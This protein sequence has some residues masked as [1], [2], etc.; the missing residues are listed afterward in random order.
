MPGLGVR[1]PPRALETLKHG[2]NRTNE[3][4]KSLKHERHGNTENKFFV[5]PGFGKFCVS[6]IKLSGG[7]QKMRFK[8]VPF[9]IIA[10][11]TLLFFYLPLRGDIIHLKGGRKFEGQIV[12]ETENELRLRIQEGIFLT[13]K[14]EHIEKIEKKK[15][16]FEICQEKLIQAKTAKDFEAAL[17]Y[18]RDE[19]LKNEELFSKIKEG[20]IS[21]RKRENPKSFCQ[22]C[23]AWGEIGC[24][25]CGRKG[26]KEAPCKECDEKGMVLC[27]KCLGSLKKTCLNCKGTGK[28]IAFCPRCRGNGRVIC[29]RCG[30]DGR[31]TCTLC[32]GD[33]RISCRN[34][35][36]DGSLKCERCGGRGW[37]RYY[38]YSRTRR[39][40]Y[41]CRGRGQ[42]DCRA[43]D[44]RGSFTCTKC[45][46]R[47]SF[48]CETCKVKG[49]LTCAQCHGTGRIE[50]KCGHCVGVGYKTCRTCQAKGKITCLNCS[51]TKIAK[52]PCQKCK[53]KGQI[54]CPECGGKGIKKQ[55]AKISPDPE[56]R[57]PGK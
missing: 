15:A 56:A 48:P 21:A 7:G 24:L 14:K 5:F 52:I 55:E 18:F 47:G 41:V 19:K 16:P 35:G 1:V 46:G 9:C 4:K 43:C 42:V 53:A 23:D 3:E 12:E 34:C 13:V 50:V 17:K 51:G 8:F 32:G 38:Y 54:I 6:V 25:E 57:Q 30:G 22:R 26:Y 37:V 2:R 33:G 36:G 28:V 49:Y 11:L 45:S 44:G 20:L 10:L 31:L 39:T 40:C 27:P 29:S